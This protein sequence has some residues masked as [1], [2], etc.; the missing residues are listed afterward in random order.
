MRLPIYINLEMILR[1]LQQRLL[2]QHAR[3]E[4]R[5]QFVCSSDPCQG[6]GRKQFVCSSDPC[7]G[8][9]EK[10]V[11][12]LLRSMHFPP[13]YKI[14]PLVLVGRKGTSVHLQSPWHC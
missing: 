7:Q 12:L 6:E 14:L 2:L 11:C 9:G 13:C 1:V 8:G 5:K 10:A 3:G 4:G